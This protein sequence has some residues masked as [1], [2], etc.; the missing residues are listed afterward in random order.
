[1]GRKE[2][3]DL[4]GQAEELVVRHKEEKVGWKRERLF[5]I[6]QALE[7][8]SIRKIAED[9]GR[10]PQ[11]IQTWI[12]K[13]R[14]GGIDALLS[15]QRGKGAKSKFTDEMKEALEKELEDGK[16]RTAKQVWSWLEENF[17]MSDF[18]PT[19][20]YTLLGKC[21]GRLKVPRP[22]NPKKDPVK[23]QE[24]RET[25]ADK[26]TELCLPKDRP[27][28]L[29]IYD[30]MRYGLH[31]LTRKVWCKRGV[32]AT[33]SSRRRYKNGYVYGALQVGGSGSEFLMTSNVDKDWDELFLN[34]ISQ[35]DPYASHVVIGDGAGFH[36]TGGEEHLPDNVF[37]LRLPP[38]CPELNPVE[39]L[40][41]IVKDGI[42]NRDWKDMA[43]L[44]D[45]LIDNLKPYWEMPQKVFSLFKN[46]YLRSELNVISN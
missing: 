40:W 30:E 15:K 19:S 10:S 37:I 8:V 18:K 46:S 33:A 1:M 27:V 39:K 14:S 44:E 17:D 26:M 31:P 5:V 20:I 4:L 24:F 9:M 16:H 38:Y 43:H 29:W 34:Q 28:R 6:K 3:I 2:K 13:Y 36:H 42:C 25:L 11:T 23:E 21:G 45:R 7:S 12:N 41:D 32:R 22:S 35:R